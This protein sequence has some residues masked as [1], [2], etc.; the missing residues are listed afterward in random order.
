[1]T[2]VLNIQ[3]D[4]AIWRTGHNKSPIAFV[5]IPDFPQGSGIQSKLSIPVG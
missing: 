5:P 1:M 3:N 4:N 2:S